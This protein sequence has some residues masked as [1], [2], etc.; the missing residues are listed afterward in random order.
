MKTLIFTEQSIIAFAESLTQEKIDRSDLSDKQK[1]I[2][3]I[4]Q[5]FEFF[6]TTNK[7]DESIEKIPFIIF[8]ET[9]NLNNFNEENIRSI[10]FE[11]HRMSI[12]ILQRNG[13]SFSMA[14]IVYKK[15]NFLVLNVL[16]SYHLFVSVHISTTNS[17]LVF[18]ITNDKRE[19]IQSAKIE[20]EKCIK[21]SEK[22]K[23]SRN[24]IKE[25][26]MQEVENLHYTNM[27]H[28]YNFNTV[29]ND[30]EQYR[31][32]FEDWKF[33]LSPKQKF[34]FENPT[35]NALKLT[36]PAGTGKTLVMQLKAIKILRENPEL[37]ILYT[38]HSWAVAYQV[39]DFIDIVAPD[40]Y[41]NIDIYPLL[42]L[43]KE[44]VHLH[45]KNVIVLGEDSY[46][47]KE[48]Q[49]KILSSIIKKFLDSDWIVYK[50]HCNE[51][52]CT[53]L[54]AIS[55]GN[56]NF[57]WEI[58]LEI[59]CVIGA[60][61]IMPGRS[62]FDKYDKTSR[63][64]WMMNLPS[65]YERK[66]V[67]QI[68]TLYMEYLLN[69][70]FI[71]SDQIINDY[72][73][74]LTTYNWFYERKKSGYDYIF[75]DEMQLFNDQEKLSLVYLSR[76]INE[77]P[78]IIMALDPKQSVEKVYVHIGIN[79]VLS[80]TNPE[81]DMS[82]GEADAFT[83][84]IAYRYTKEILNFLKHIDASYPQMDLSEYWDNGI[85]SL[86]HNN[87]KGGIEPMLYTYEDNND[88]LMQALELAKKYSQKGLQ[89]II[90]SLQED[91]FS[92]LGKLTIDRQEY[93]QILSKSDVGVLKYTKKKVYIS[94]PIHV[95]GL[96]FDVV[97]LIGCYTLF[98]QHDSNQSH[99][100]R[101]FL[102][103][104]YLGASRAKKVLFLTNN[105]TNPILPNFL[106]K[107]IEKK[108][109]TPAST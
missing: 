13:L 25:K 43:A 45:D 20:Y 53:K 36:G 66:V 57:T 89:T 74:H 80:K 23:F 87:I 32:T 21:N 30:K 81:T 64:N 10:L 107:A 3:I 104:L 26:Y 42:E 99:Y 76:N 19:K 94:K 14:S 28:F 84:D 65:D 15:D 7:K 54:E 52:F 33:K 5:D 103:D 67:F 75:V 62:S 11:V 56:N 82:M 8:E 93:H 40:I 17:I 69:H 109:L 59:A 1:Y 91:L 102:S 4:D 44:K 46:E 68:Y 92:D 78:K 90:L 105:K 83:L 97:I 39:S 27:D 106:E 12:Q 96:Q 31:Y 63:R 50:S 100:Q 98:D 77:Y 24:Q 49:V 108:Y 61:G 55:S 88:E 95:I 16:N 73:N 22:I 70:G 41:Q 72:I 71:S 47:G 2:Q 37:R 9:L 86:K 48:R 101:I 60:N 58:M 38:C 79:E 18:K 29:F 34:F 85:A 51:E 35:K 6:F